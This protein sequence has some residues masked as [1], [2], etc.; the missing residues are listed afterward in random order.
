MPNDRTKIV[1]QDVDVYISAAGTSHADGSTG[2]TLVGWCEAESIT[3]TT[4]EVYSEDL[5][6]M[7]PHQHA[8][9]VEVAAVAMETDDAK[10]A[11]LEGFINSDIDI[12]LINRSDR[13]AGWVISGTGGGLTMAPDF[14]F[15]L[16][17]ANRI[18]LT[19]AFVG[20][21][22]SDM[23]SALSGATGYN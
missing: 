1:A 3:L 13:S 23:Y 16:N 18:N 20:K 15:S 22:F 21:V 19:A 17:A 6:N 11:A 14:K 9:K 4:P 10:I 7:T 5:H 12:V 8:L 2:H